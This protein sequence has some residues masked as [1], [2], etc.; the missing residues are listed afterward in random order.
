MCLPDDVLQP[1][2]LA[3]AEAV[4]QDSTFKETKHGIGCWILDRAS[5]CLI[6]P[7]AFALRNHLPA[8][9]D[10]VIC[11]DSVLLLQLEM[12]AEQRRSLYHLQGD[13][14]WHRRLVS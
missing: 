6:G 4:L 3:A 14:A 12:L 1:D 2:V 9:T 8:G 5:L 10:R 11:T 7:V 13:Q